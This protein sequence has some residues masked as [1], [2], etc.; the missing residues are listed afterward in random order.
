MSAKAV[1]TPDLPATGDCYRVALQMLWVLPGWVLVH[2]R[3]TM[4]REPFCQYGHAWVEDPDRR[5]VIDPQGYVVA[6]EIYYEA[7]SIDPELS[8]VYTAA[9]ARKK[10][11]EFEHYGPWEGVDAAPRGGGHV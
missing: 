5:T 10:L 9:E 8:F 11:V 3:P 1:R 7:G 6:R 4:T 2:G